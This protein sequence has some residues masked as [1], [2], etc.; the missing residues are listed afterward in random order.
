MDNAPC[1]DVASGA[2]RGVAGGVLT[3]PEVSS[4]AMF[5]HLTE[6]SPPPIRLDAIPVLSPL[7]D[8]CWN[9]NTL[10]Y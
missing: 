6:F 9:L 8:Y 7:K 2:T 1:S 3:L 5:S 4:T 10:G